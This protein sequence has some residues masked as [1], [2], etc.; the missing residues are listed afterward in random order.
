MDLN[1]RAVRGRRWCACGE[2]VDRRKEKVDL[3][4]IEEFKESKSAR[5]LV[6]CRGRLLSGRTGLVTR[7]ESVRRTQRR[8]GV[9]ILRTQIF[10]GD[11]GKG[12]KKRKVSGKQKCACWPQPE[13]KF[14]EIEEFKEVRL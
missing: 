2:K 8:A 12:S 14:K 10:A 13:L 6:I 5:G 3:R 11:E 9:P 4:Q 7:P 1:W